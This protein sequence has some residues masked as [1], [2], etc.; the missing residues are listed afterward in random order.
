MRDFL[1]GPEKD[2]FVSLSRNPGRE[3]FE[4]I[5]RKKEIAGY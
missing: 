2:V 4:K 3:V 5:M 1:K